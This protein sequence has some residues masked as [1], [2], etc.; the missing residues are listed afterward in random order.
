[1]LGKDKNRETFEQ[2]TKFFMRALELDPNYS[3]A[4]A[5]LG[6]GVHVRLPKSLE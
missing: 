3:Q 2:A 1:M 5:G 4:Y 6:F